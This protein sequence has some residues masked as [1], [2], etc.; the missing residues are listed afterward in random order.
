[1]LKVV[2]KYAQQL[3]RADVRDVLNSPAASAIAKR[4]GV[5]VL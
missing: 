3:S 1:M 2:Q 5:E 4:L